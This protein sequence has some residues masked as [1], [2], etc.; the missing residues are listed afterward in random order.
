MGETEMNAV[1]VINQRIA[2]T[3][4]QDGQFSPLARVTC[5]DGFSVS[6]QAGQYVYSA[7]RDDIGSWVSF[8]LGFP[9]DADDLIL[10]YAEDADQPTETVYGYVPASVVNDLIAKHGGLA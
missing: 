7:P 10:L 4:R 1:D 9:S 3:K 8:E 2:S 5:S 6:I